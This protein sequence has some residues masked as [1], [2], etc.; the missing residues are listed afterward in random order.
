MD[1]V[2]EP[3]EGK[4]RGVRQ[5]APP[6]LDPVLVRVLRPVVRRA[7]LRVPPGAVGEALSP[8]PLRAEAAGSVRHVPIG[9]RR[10]RWPTPRGEAVSA[11]D[12]AR[13]GR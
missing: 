6:G 2:G 7:P 11:A 9:P 5:G 1:A 13:H 10:G 8:L 12:A 3:A 4:R